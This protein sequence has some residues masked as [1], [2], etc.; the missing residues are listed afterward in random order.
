MSAK[1]LA[2]A[3]VREGTHAIYPPCYR[4]LGETASILG[5]ASRLIGEFSCAVK[6]DLFGH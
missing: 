4:G 6:V 2:L 1:P 3:M 5:E